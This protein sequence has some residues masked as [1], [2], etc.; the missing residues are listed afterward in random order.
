MVFWLKSF[1]Y[2]KY[3]KC[4][5]I[6]LAPCIRRILLSA[7]HKGS[8]SCCPFLSI[9]MIFYFF[10]DLGHIAYEHILKASAASFPISLFAILFLI[11]LIYIG[12]LQKSYFVPLIFFAQDFYGT[13]FH[14]HSFPRN[15]SGILNIMTVHNL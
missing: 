9:Q 7:A 8:V 12:T 10:A 3:K 15:H 6:P 11:I 14:D 5:Q 2:S 13:Q 1:I 4:P